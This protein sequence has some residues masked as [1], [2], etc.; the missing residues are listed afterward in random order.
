VHVDV[1]EL[2]GVI[3]H[4]DYLSQLTDETKQKNHIPAAE[5]IIEEIKKNSMF[6]PKEEKPTIHALKEKLNAM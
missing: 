1:E 3:N 5:A 6:G 4:M 2:D